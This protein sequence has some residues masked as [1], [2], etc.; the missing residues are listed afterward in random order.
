MVLAEEL[1]QRAKD[2]VGGRARASFS[3]VV[4]AKAG[5]HNH[6]EQCE[7]KRPL[8]AFAK[9]FPVGMGPGL[10]LRAPRDDS[11]ALATPAD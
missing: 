5:T 11:V 10:A 8:R 2:E 9:H 6:R 3:A 4:P 7:A 1:E